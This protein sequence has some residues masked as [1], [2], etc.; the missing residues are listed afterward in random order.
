M[1][2]AYGFVRFSSS[3]VLFYEYDGTADVVIPRLHETCQ[4]VSD[5]WR[6]EGERFQQL[7]V[8]EVV[9]PQMEAGL[10]MLRH[11]LHRYRTDPEEV[12]QLVVDLRQHLSF[13][14]NSE[15]EGAGLP[16]EGAP[17][18]LPNLEFTP[19]TVELANDD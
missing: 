12:D 16:E 19:N 10:E 3:E 13:G 9:W 18:S 1:S 6:G 17:G 5:N 11:S 4:G 14:V 7:G 8:Q 2:H 15:A